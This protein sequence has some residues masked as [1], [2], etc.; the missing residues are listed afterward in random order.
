MDY[1]IYSII[2]CVFDGIKAVKRDKIEKGHSVQFIDDLAS[3]GRAW[4]ERAI[5]KIIIV[6]L[7]GN[8][9]KAI[10]IGE[11]AYCLKCIEMTKFRNLEECRLN[12]ALE[13]ILKCLYWNNL[14]CIKANAVLLGD[15]IESF[16]EVET[17]QKN[18]TYGLWFNPAHKVYDLDIA[19]SEV[20]LRQ[21]NE[22][23][24]T[25]EYMF[26][27]CYVKQYGRK[28]DHCAETRA[29]LN[30][31]K[32]RFNKD[33]L[34]YCNIEYRQHMDEKKRVAYDLYEY[35]ILKHIQDEEQDSFFNE[36]CPDSRGRLYVNND[37]G[38]YIGLKSL[39]GLI[40]FD[41]V[42]MA[43]TDAIED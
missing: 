20:G 23:I 9:E 7:H 30:G 37:M 33:L 28:K 34:Q 11:L 22:E 12:Q 26:G 24:K 40:Q 2:E 29:L 36:Y 27:H 39:R 19:E 21:G 41:K 10:Y 6:L 15:K 18:T 13:L 8:E 25:T 38:N 43:E 3:L 14:L 17:G 35:K 32:L 4:W 5:K 42:E 16:D 31:V 1:S